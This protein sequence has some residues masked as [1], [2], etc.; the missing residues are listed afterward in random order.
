MHLPD[1]WRIFK[2]VRVVHK[3]LVHGVDLERVAERCP[4]MCTYS[5]ILCECIHVFCR[6]KLIIAHSVHF[7]RIPQRC[8]DMW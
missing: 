4:D 5:V 3:A 6:I 2:H 1:F 7:E 8:S